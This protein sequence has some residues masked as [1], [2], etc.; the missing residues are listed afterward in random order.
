M[1]K[2]QLGILLL[3]V[4]VVAI[5]GIS[6]FRE[7]QKQQLQIERSLQRKAAEASRHEDMALLQQGGPGQ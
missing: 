6:K 1:T 4:L 5:L 7:Q 2:N 3:V